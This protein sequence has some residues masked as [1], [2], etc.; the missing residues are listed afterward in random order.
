MKIKDIKDEKLRELALERSDFKGDNIDLMEAFTWNKTPE[1][2]D[3]WKQSL[4]RKHYA[5]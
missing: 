4:P 1:G 2:N 5:Y 3:F